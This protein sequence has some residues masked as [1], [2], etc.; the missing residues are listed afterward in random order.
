MGR[1]MVALLDQNK[2][3]SKTRRR[4]SSPMTLGLS[5]CLVSAQDTTEQVVGRGVLRACA[6]GGPLLGE[7]QTDAPP[8]PS[9]RVRTPGRGQG[10]PAAGAA[11]SSHPCYP[12]TCTTEGYLSTT[13]SIAARKTEYPT[14]K[15]DKRTN[16]QFA[17][18][19]SCFIIT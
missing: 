14:G 5:V 16:R 12:A 13:Q 9:Q 17:Q 18:K 11:P 15:T 8:E 4:V 7:R 19:Q 1:E 10:A 3:N 2:Q 6:L